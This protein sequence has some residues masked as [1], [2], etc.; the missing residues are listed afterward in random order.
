MGEGSKEVRLQFE[1]RAVMARDLRQRQTD[2][3]EALWEE[4]RDRRFQGWKFRRQ[5]PIGPYFADFCSEILH[6]VVEVDGGVHLTDEAKAYDQER[7][8]YMRQ[9]GFV[10]VRLPADDV[11]KRIDKVK[12]DLLEAIAQILRNRNSDHPSPTGRGDGGE[13]KDGTCRG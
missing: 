4:L 13:G 7:D 9:A 10:V 11:G 3:E 6:L 1:G 2:S 8:E 12:C 5:R